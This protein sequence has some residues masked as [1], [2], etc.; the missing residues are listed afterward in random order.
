MG[1]IDA[2]VEQFSKEYSKL[3][4]HEISARVVQHEKDSAGIIAGLLLKNDYQMA[5][6][7]EKMAKDVDWTSTLGK[8]KLAEAVH[9]LIQQMTVPEKVKEQP[10]A[11]TEKARDNLEWLLSQGSSFEVKA[12][13]KLRFAQVKLKHKRYWTPDIAYA[14][15][16]SNHLSID[17]VDKAKFEESFKKDVEQTYL[18]LFGTSELDMIAFLDIYEMPEFSQEAVDAFYKSQVAA[19][20]RRSLK[21]LKY[22]DFSFNKFGL[23]VEYKLG[24]FEPAKDLVDKIKAFVSGKNTKTISD[25]G[26]T[27][28]FKACVDVVNSKWF[29]GFNTKQKRLQD[30]ATELGTDFK[31]Q[32][33]LLAV[34]AYKES[35]DNDVYG[36]VSLFGIDADAAFA[37]AWTA[38][39]IVKRYT[40][41]AAGEQTVAKLHEFYQYLKSHKIQ[42]NPEPAIIGAAIGQRLFGE[43]PNTEEAKSISKWYAALHD[44]A[45]EELKQ[46]LLSLGTRVTSIEQ[47]ESVCAVARSVVPDYRL[48]KEVGEGIMKGYIGS[49]NKTATELTN[50]DSRLKELCGSFSVPQEIAAKILNQLVEGIQ[51]V[52]F[53][54]LIQHIPK[55]AHGVNKHNVGL[56]VQYLV[57]ESG[58][59]AE[60][61]AHRV[62]ILAN[63]VE[64]AAG[65]GLVCYGI[66]AQTL[67]PLYDTMNVENGKD[68]YPH[69]FN[70]Y[71]KLYEK[72]STIVPSGKAPVAAEP[73]RVEGHTG[74]SVEGATSGSS[75]ALT[76]AAVKKKPERKARGAHKAEVEAAAQTKA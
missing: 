42:T 64:S 28:L 17:K 74:G 35:R 1:N 68:K 66:Q 2:V 72:V 65:N 61:K 22:V 75:A 76:E 58:L 37:G 19:Y 55:Y 45:R 18:S 57:A 67:K 16:A 54:I 60:Q 34:A 26:V 38:D 51:G 20:L 9:N 7:V 69:V 33:H 5:K 13:D 71:D 36:L 47:A 30:I 70:Q 11:V 40:E 6:T 24:K 3:K 8:V 21:P 62:V 59:S 43:K 31:K 32:G 53:D 29:V 63:S 23:K 50:L 27:S 10:D 4:P 46:E 41:L 48:S 15:G 12:D 39:T 49:S 56:A 25:D 44:S 73:P 14:E 52:G